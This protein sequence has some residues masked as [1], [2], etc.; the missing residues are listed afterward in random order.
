MNPTNSLLFFVSTL[1]IAGNCSLLR[2][3]PN[4]KDPQEVGLQSS[5][6]T[7]NP[8]EP[9]SR[10]SVIGSCIHITNGLPSYCKESLYSNPDLK[11]GESDSVNYEKIM[12]SFC[13]AQNT[14]G[15]S[16]SGVA[17][18]WQE[19]KACD[20]KNFVGTCLDRL[21]T[22][23]W[24][25]GTDVITSYKAG[26]SVCK[27]TKGRWTRNPA[28]QLNISDNDI[29]PAVILNES[30]AKMKPL[31]RTD[32]KAIENSTTGTK[33]GA[34]ITYF[35]ASVTQ[36]E[37]FSNASEQMA[38]LKKATCEATNTKA[39]AQHQMRK[40]FK[41]DGRCP[42]E[43]IIGRCRYKVANTLDQVET[44]YAGY[45]GSF[46]RM[47]I[48]EAKRDIRNRLCEKIFRGTWSTQ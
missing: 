46:S 17:S 4:S 41:S 7:T 29:D 11:G 25:Q 23:V 45:A 40:I 2:A 33:V 5:I 47:S 39:M 14:S 3:K 21:G 8:R 42:T 24:Y 12:P 37:S 10:G 27:L 13:Q 28:L 18:R 43:N 44:W 9:A 22:T 30:L 34:C 26:Y 35:K 15:S 38:I 48:E 16:A 31:T 1:Y 36:C 19:G 6:E 32:L 20:R